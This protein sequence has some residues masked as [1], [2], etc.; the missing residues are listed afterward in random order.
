M[1]TFSVPTP[2][3]VRDVGETAVELRT[4]GTQVERLHVSNPSADTVGWFKAWDVRSANLNT[5]T[6]KMLFDHPV[7]P[8]QSLVIEELPLLLGLTVRF[9]GAAGA[10]DESAPAADAILHDWRDE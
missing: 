7:P 4:S 10:A 1:P 9:T 5:G 2:N 8:G 3:I 6:S